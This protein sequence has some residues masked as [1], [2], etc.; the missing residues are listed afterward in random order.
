MTSLEGEE[1]VSSLPLGRTDRLLLVVTTPYGSI[2]VSMSIVS[3]L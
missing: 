1:P 3:G 2:V